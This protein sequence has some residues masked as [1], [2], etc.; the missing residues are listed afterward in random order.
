MVTSFNHASAWAKA[1]RLTTHL[2]EHGI[3]AFSTGNYCPTMI[4]NWRDVTAEG[5]VNC[6][7]L[8]ALR[9]NG[10]QKSQEGQYEIKIAEKRREK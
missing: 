6:K 3:K 9:S 1:V 2:N 10:W 4:G 8:I 7:V 5:I